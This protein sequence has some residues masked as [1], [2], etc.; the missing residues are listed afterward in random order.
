VPEQW[1][2]FIKLNRD[3]FNSATPPGKPQ[4]KG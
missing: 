4:K 3:V 1:K 2:D